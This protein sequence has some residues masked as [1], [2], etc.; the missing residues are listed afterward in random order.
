[1]NESYGQFCTVAR[2]AE[3]LC[4][5][6]TPLVVRELLCGSKRFNELHR[7]V[8]RMS[9]GLLAQRLRHLEEIGVVHRTAVG[10]VWEYSLTEAGEELRPIIMAL[11]HWGARWIGSRLRDDQLDAGLLMW[12]VRRF[13]RLETFPSRPV[14][15]QFKFRDARS[16]EQAWWLVVEE[17]V[18]DLCRDDPGRELTLVVDSSVR[19]LTEVWAGDRTPREVLESRELRV[20]GAAQDAQNLWRWLGT[21]AFASTR[22]SAR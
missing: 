18:A 7:G 4:E 20:D 15:I 16:G 11:G 12:D 10:K 9:T 22:S 13:V 21:S 2:G 8:P 1:M 6:W 19:A 17:G 5:R 3:A 14:V